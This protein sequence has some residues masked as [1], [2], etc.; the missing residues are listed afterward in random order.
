M[1]KQVGRILDVA[2][3]ENWSVVLTADHGNCEEMTI[4]DTGGPHTQ[5]TTFPVPC[6]VIDKMQWQLADNA[7]LSSVAPTVL[8]LMGLEQPA[9]MK[10][11]SLL[12]APVAKAI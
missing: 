2:V 6:M 11:K 4:H 5:H 10:S 1:D 7:G 3:R 12:V 8:Q 9:L